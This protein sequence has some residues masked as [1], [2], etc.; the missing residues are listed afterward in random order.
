MT[1]RMLHLD[2]RRVLVGMGGVGAAGLLGLR[3]S[4]AQAQAAEVVL[5]NYG[6]KQTDTMKVAFTD[7][8]TK[9]TGIPVVYDSSGPNAG[10]IRAMMEG[11]TAL[12]DVCD[13]SPSIGI[14]LGDEN[15]LEEI[16]YSIV[17]AKK[18]PEG[19]AGKYSVGS[20]LFSTVI[21]YNKKVLADRV[22]QTWADF[23]NVKDFPG[24]RTLSRI[25]QSVL[26]AALMADGVPPDQLY[27]I[28]VMRALEKVK[29]IKEHTL[30]WKTAAEAIE[31]MRSG[32]ATIGQLWSTRAGTVKAETKGD[33]DYHW[34]QGVLMSAAW[35]VPKGNPAGR[36]NAMKLIAYMQNPERQAQWLRTNMNGP[37][38]P[39]ATK[40][41]T[42]EEINLSPGAA[43]NRTT[44]VLMNYEWLAANYTTVEPQ[45]IEAIA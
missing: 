35:V 16:D 11:G 22:P 20:Y 28:D 14:D 6:G 36:A 39:E 30:F 9:E 44:Q 12:W 40:F 3:P 10:K 18:V 33:V 2:R 23:W 5:S 29:E 43:V 19:L 17:D 37:I 26:E 25:S 13:S 31:F 15:L 42:P 21:T 45:Y 7:G 41:L 24:K 1:E 38:N 4:L 27:P 8:F 34:N 32:E